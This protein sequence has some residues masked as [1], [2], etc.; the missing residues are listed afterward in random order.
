MNRFHILKDKK[1]PSQVRTLRKN[2][3]IFGMKGWQGQVLDKSTITMN[4]DEPAY[5]ILSS[6][7]KFNIEIH[8]DK[9]HEFSMDSI[10]ATNTYYDVEESKEMVKVT[11]HGKLRLI[12]SMI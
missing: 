11:L 3:F 5:K 9:I 7:S 2:N 4:I 1:I 12:G 8:T 10:L 6:V